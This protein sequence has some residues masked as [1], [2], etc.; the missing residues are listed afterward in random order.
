[1]LFI[2]VISIVIAIIKQVI[3]VGTRS[4]DEAAFVI[5]ASVK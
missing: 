4:L 2:V 3:Q 5:R 1:M